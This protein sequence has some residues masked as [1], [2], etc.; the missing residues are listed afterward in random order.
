MIGGIR[1]GG[2]ACD[3]SGQE[4][5]SDIERDPVPDIACTPLANRNQAYGFVDRYQGNHG[6]KRH[7][8]AWANQGLR[9]PQQNHHRCPGNGSHRQNSPVDQHRHQHQGDHQ[10]G[11]LRRHNASGQ[12]QIG[13][14]RDQGQLRPSIQ[15]DTVNPTAPNC[16]NQA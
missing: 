6:G 5:A 15:G 4:N 1:D 10:E 14:S 3:Q 2:C 13:K 11:T 8:K 7:L 9:P 12:Q 16:W